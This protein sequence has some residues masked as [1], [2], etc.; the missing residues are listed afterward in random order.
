M[1]GRFESVTLPG[2]QH[3]GEGQASSDHSE[4]SQQDH[5][6]DEHH[7]YVDKVHMITSGSLRSGTPLD[8]I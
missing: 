2:C 7:E 5:E 1:P 4:Q 6:Q 8:M 3:A